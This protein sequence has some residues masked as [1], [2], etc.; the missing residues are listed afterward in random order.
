MHGDACYEK[1]KYLSDLLVISCLLLQICGCN[2]TATLCSFIVVCRLFFFPSKEDYN[3]TAVCTL[4]YLDEI[5]R[6]R[7]L[8]GQFLK[9]V[10]SLI[11]IAHIFSQCD[12]SVK[13]PD[14]IPAKVPF[15]KDKIHDR[16]T[17][18]PVVIAHSLEM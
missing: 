12:T 6:A 10:K 15:A 9:I 18:S 11:G 14:I 8:L 1:T 7:R 4:Q 17:L 16:I 2:E 13:L 3:L 5:P